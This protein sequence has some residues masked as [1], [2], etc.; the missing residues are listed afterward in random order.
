VRCA[1]FEH[2]GSH[3]PSTRRRRSQSPGD[4]CKP[5]AWR[6]ALPAELLE[7][8]KCSVP[9]RREWTAYFGPRSPD[10]SRDLAVQRVGRAQ[11]CTRRTSRIRPMRFGTATCA[12]SRQAQFNAVVPLRADA[13]H[14]AFSDNVATCITNNARV[15]RGKRRCHLALMPTIARVFR[16]KPETGNCSSP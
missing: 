5:A 11:D 10:R 4:R 13:W 14:C 3:S 12:E 7:R 16:A 2:A 15:W 9:I 8:A 1:A 6:P